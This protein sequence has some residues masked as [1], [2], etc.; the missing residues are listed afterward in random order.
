MSKY[1]NVYMSE[2]SDKIIGRIVENTL[3]DVWDGK[4]YSYGG[5]GNHGGISKLKRT[6]EDKQFVFIFTTQWQGV[7]NRAWLISDEEALQY[8]LNSE[9]DSLLSKYFKNYDVNLEEDD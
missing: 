9:D 8:I 4:N 6:I 7:K 2:E 1:I 5:V 3:L